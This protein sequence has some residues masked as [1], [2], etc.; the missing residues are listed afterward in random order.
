[1]RNNTRAIAA[2]ILTAVIRDKYS[3]TD[4]FQQN[5]PSALPDCD[6]GLIKEYCYGVLRWY[7]R[8]QIIANLLVYKPVK[9]KEQDIASLLVLGLYQLI[10]LHTPD[11]AA[12]S[13]TVAAAQT[14]QKPWA[15]GLIN[16]AL[17]QFISRRDFFLQQADATWVG[18]FAH[19]Q[20]MIEA[21]K[22]AWPEQWQAI[23]SANNCQAPMFLRVNVQQNTREEYLQR[24]QQHAIEAT[25]VESLPQAIRLTQPQ[26][27]DHL[28]G[29]HDGCCSV[30]DLASQYIVQILELAP[31]QRVLDACAAPGGKTA[32]ILEAQPDLAQCIALDQDAGRLQRV[33]ENIQRL[34]LQTRLQILAA[35][36]ARPDTWWDGQYFDRIL[37][38]APCSGTGV[39]RRHPDIKVLRRPA[40]IAAYAQQQWA[41]LTALWPLLKPGGCLLYTTCSIFPEENTQL[42]SRFCS[43]YTDAK[44]LPIPFNVGL[45]QETGR[46][47]FPTLDA[48][49]GFYYA[50]L[51]KSAR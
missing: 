21:L 25:P 14:M 19:P 43:Q 8:L 46:Q 28:P 38:D 3:L 4:M 24:L 36:A 5:I 27:V 2:K 12:V 31:H 44:S 17:R 51:S 33:E 49:D 26:P 45:P 34:K 40:D 6:R 11:H 30:Q 23:L 41:L 29:F 39:I 32:H 22:K 16:Q 37:L 35:D 42:I 1:M 9:S 47:L 7:S 13:E 10:Y 15:K 20:W 18:K 48:H 50:L